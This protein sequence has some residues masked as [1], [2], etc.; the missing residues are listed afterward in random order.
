MSA[1]QTFGFSSFGAAAAGAWGAPH[2]RPDSGGT[3]L[4]LST[5]VNVP[6][7][8]SIAY[9]VTCP[10]NSL[11]TYKFLLSGEKARWRG[12]CPASGLT[13]AG[14]LAVS[15]PVLLSKVNCSTWLAPSVA[16]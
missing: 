2:A 12:P 8:A 15:L 5:T 9:C 7:P 4:M 11:S 3:E 10:D 1:A 6:L 14:L 13:D 16:A